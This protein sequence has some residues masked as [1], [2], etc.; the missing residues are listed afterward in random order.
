MNQPEPFDPATRRAL[1]LTIISV[2]VLLSLRSAWVTEDAYITLRTVDNWVNGYGLRWN[3]NERVQAY[4]HPLWMLVLSA[5][6][7]VT[8]EDFLS[9]AL[10]GVVATAT[11][12][13][14]LSK[15]SRTGVHAFVAI[16]LLVVSRSFIDFSTSG[17]ENSLSHL[18]IACFVLL[19][20]VR[21]ARLLW[22]SLIGA[23][24][25]LNRVD[26]LL[27][28]LP[29]LGH[30]LFE[31]A[32][33]Q[34][35]R[36]TARDALLGFCPLFAWELFSLLYYGFLVPNTAFAKLN[37]GIPS[38]ELAEQGALYLLYSVAFDPAIVIGITLGLGT[39]CLTR[40]RRTLLLAFG[41]LLYLAYVMRVGGDFM[42][43]RFLTLPL[44]LSACLVGRA[45][46][47]IERPQIAAAMLLPFVVLWFHPH[48]TESWPVTDLARTGI[49]DE[50]A[51]YR[52]DAS[53]MMTARTKGMP[54]FG[55][56]VMGRRLRAE[57]ATIDESGNVGFRGF[58]A[59]PDVYIIDF[60]ALTDALLARLPARHDPN[61]R[62]GHYA[63]TI[64]VNY[65]ATVEGDK[66]TMPDANLCAYYGK[67]RMIIAGDVWS[68]ERLKTIVAMNLGRYD[69]LIDFERYRYPEVLKLPLDQ[70]AVPVAEVGP[71]DAP[72][73]RTFGTD[74]VEIALGKVVTVPALD[75][76]LDVNDSYEFVYRLGKETVATRVSRIAPRFDRHIKTPSRAK[77]RG[78]DTLVIRPRQ[79]DGMYSIGN[80]RLTATG[81]RH[82]PR[83]AQ[84]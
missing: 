38:G 42:M 48:A 46:L 61:W 70:V 33:E 17:L 56:A 18:L 64:P 84:R 54:S 30:A 67:L 40:E 49:A 83:T 50:R 15:L 81:S 76:R 2:L 6:Y 36:K 60:H 72:G 78:F 47:A 55:W 80:L 19:Y 10:A 75:V 22:L 26:S 79:G 39:A 4:T 24:M 68:W 63:R 28:V 51:Y 13:L 34:G 14:V 69:H 41:I 37:T 74:G 3:T 57:R 27:L 8:R 1:L 31:S 73:T 43:G 59:G 7:F 9:T 16:A 65:R 12:A 11:A 53:L 66:C 77:E 58:F 29:A 35:V 5:I 45:N 44:M 20:A 25:A 52:S 21:R 71:W 23:L 32:R 62:V 82:G